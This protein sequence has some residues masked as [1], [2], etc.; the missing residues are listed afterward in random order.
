V[1]GG[2]TRAA[3]SVASTIAESLEELRI[4]RGRVLLSLI[5]VAAAVCAL[6]TVVAAGAIA[7]QAGR[8]LQ[9][10]SGGRPATYTVNI[11]APPSEATVPGGGAN[12]TADAAWQAALERHEIDWAG[13]VGW[14]SLSVQFADG[15]VP[16]QL[17]VVDPDYGP[18]HRVALETGAWFTERDVDRLAPAVIVNHAF[19]ERLGRPPL[20]SHP[21]VQFVSGGAETTAVVTGVTP[22][23]GEWDTE[24]TGFMLTEGFL[25]AQPVATPEF[26]AYAPSYEMWL[27]EGDA[28]AIA[29]SVVRAISAELGGRA[30]VNAMRSDYA[31]MEGDPYLPV[32]LVVTGIAVVILLLG[33]LGLVTISLVTVR[34]RIREIGVRR[35]FGATAGRVFFAVLMESVVGTFVAGVVGVGLAIVLVRGPLMGM[36]LGGMAV[37]DLPGFPVEAAII[38]IV[39]AVAVGALAGLL[40]A[41]TAVRV[42]VIDA[43]RF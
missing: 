11:S 33:A 39:S 2:L 36:L 3:T 41:L 4:H 34:A 35:S 5:G 32:K 26:G 27:P 43:I 15:V 20:S 6:A 14:G 8:E 18:M 24:P 30:S 12:E 31:Q 25:A 19:W 29:D 38:G 10:R 16:A 37:Q 13:R 17:Q 23:Q 9:E 1:I 40:P 21:T 22:S 7:E 42:K 28:Q